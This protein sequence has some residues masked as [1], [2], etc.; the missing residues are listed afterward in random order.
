MI[1]LTEDERKKIRDSIIAD[2]TDPEVK[3]PAD[4]TKLK[5]DVLINDRGTGSGKDAPAYETDDVT[6]DDVGS[7]PSTV[8]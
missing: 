7:F 4:K 2:L 5:L 6:E 8:H 3:T 1:N